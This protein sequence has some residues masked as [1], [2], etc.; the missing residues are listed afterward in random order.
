MFR[1]SRLIIFAIIGWLTLTPSAASQLAP[2]SSQKVE[3]SANSAADQKQSRTTKT[4]GSRNFG[5]REQTVK[6]DCGT[7]KECR[8]EQRD[9][10]D[11]IAQQIAAKAAA[12]QARSS[13]WQTGVGAAGVILLILTVAYTHLATKAAVNA[14]STLIGV[15]R[16]RISL[17][18]IGGTTTFDGSAASFILALLNNGRTAGVL[19]ESCVQGSA[20]GLFADFEPTNIMKHNTVISMDKPVHFRDFEFTLNDEANKF[21]VGYYKFSTIFSKRIY[22]DYFCLEV[23]ELEL[24]LEGDGL[25]QRVVSTTY[26]TDLDWP[27][28]EE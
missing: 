10:D 4:V 13:W 22:T 24:P 23:G 17:C 25:V 14:V 12:D 18:H 20:T 3:T 16:A 21:L 6:S 1:S 15:E 9:K 19:K 27:P 8:S 5:N 7:P 28:D 2:A 26:R 11:L